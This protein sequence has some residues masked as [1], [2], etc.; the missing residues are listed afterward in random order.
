MR[1]SSPHPGSTRTRLT[2]SP[3]THSGHTTSGWAPEPASGC[4]PAAAAGL[5]TPQRPLHP[6]TYHH[7]KHT[8]THSSGSGSGS[9]RTR[10]GITHT[11]KQQRQQ[12]A[13][14][15][16]DAAGAAPPAG[17]P[18]MASESCSSCPLAQSL[19]IGRVPSGLVSVTLRERE[20]RRQNGSCREADR[21]SCDDAVMCRGLPGLGVLVGARRAGQQEGLESAPAG[22]PAWVSPPAG[23]AL[24]RVACV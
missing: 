15:A 22:R 16:A 14:S 23:P 21:R 9:R 20:G 6:D 24:C 12:Q 13:A 10:D 8:H 3:T 11:Q 5:A 17:A 18:E 1:C 2:P 7:H 4:P 19:R